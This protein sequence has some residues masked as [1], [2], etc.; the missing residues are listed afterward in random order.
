MHHSLVYL[1]LLY[2]GCSIKADGILGIFPTRVPLYLQSAQSNVP[3]VLLLT[4]YIDLDAMSL[5]FGKT[6][7][8]TDNHK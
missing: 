3:Y 1:L 6:V 2:A 8:L 4:V 5:D 7:D